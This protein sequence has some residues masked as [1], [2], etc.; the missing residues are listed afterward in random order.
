MF[1]FKDQHG[2]LVKACVYINTSNSCAPAV[3]MLVLCGV[4][5]EYVPLYLDINQEIIE[6]FDSI[7]L[8]HTDRDIYAS[9]CNMC[10]YDEQR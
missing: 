8:L 3:K 4:A 6:Q 9:I 10:K 2:F 1:P 7:S 5:C